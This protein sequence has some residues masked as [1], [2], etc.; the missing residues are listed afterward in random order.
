M[1]NYVL[2][3]YAL[4]S[5]CEGEPEAREVAGFFKKALSNKIRLFLSVVNWGEMYY[6][7]LR[8]GGRERAE[9]YRSTIANYPVKIVNA[10]QELTLKAAYYKGSFQISYADAYAAA[11]TKLQ[12]AVLITGD[13]EFRWL[14]KEISIH[15]LS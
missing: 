15:W 1:K 8:E 2:D 14:E 13:S 7:A 9:S 3:S 12:R 11:L 6:I 5:Y 10:D 4:L